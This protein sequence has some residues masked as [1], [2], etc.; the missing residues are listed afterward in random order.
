MR[1]FLIAWGYAFRA[2][3]GFV[4]LVVQVASACLRAVPPWP[5]LDMLPPIKL[6]AVRIIDRLKPEYRHSL[7]THG[8]SLGNMPARS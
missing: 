4:A 6:A 7:A 2:L 8:L 3:F 1:S 5:A